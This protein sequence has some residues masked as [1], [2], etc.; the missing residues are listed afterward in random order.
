MHACMPHN[1]QVVAILAAGSQELP[2]KVESVKLDLPELQVQ[3]RS[4][5]HLRRFEDQR[6]GCVQLAHRYHDAAVGSKSA[7]CVQ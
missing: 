4:N 2:F 3:A 6:H 7:L 1:M 5:M